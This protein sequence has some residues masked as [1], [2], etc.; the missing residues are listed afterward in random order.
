MKFFSF[1]NMALTGALSIAGLGLVG[2]G[3]HAIF[4]TSSTSS[5]TISAGTPQVVLSSTNAANGCTTIAIAVANPGTCAGTI[6]LNP[7]PVFGSTFDTAA[8]TVYATNTGNIPVTETSIQM[9]VVPSAVPADLALYNEA[10]VCVHNWDTSFGGSLGDNGWVE[11][12]A[13]LSVAVGRTPSVT[14]NPVVIAPGSSIN[15]SMEFYAGQDS[16]CGTVY[17]A[18]P[19]TAA[20]YYDLIGHW[21]ATPASLN[22]DAESGTITPTFTLNYSA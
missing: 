18:G 20:A 6:T 5:Q 8:S 10:S 9:G 13:P 16:T 7:P 15:F 11:V 1:R 22:P 12:N 2:I 19:N 17:S 3:A 4:T 14:E 21:Y